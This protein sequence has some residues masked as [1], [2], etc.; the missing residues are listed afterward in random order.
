MKSHQAEAEAEA[1]DFLEAEA[2]AEARQTIFM[3]KPSKNQE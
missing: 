1:L 2:E 3:A